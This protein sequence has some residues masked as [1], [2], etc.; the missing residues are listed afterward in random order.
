MTFGEKAEYIRLELDLYIEVDSANPARF[1]DS[2]QRNACVGEWRQIKK[3]WMA[4]PVAVFHP[5]RGKPSS[6]GSEVGLENRNL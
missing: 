2:S 6:V 1:C 4:H 3:A 5:E